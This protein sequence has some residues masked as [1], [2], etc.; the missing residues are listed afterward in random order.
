MTI[1]YLC[2]K[3]GK[4]PVSHIL[5][6]I[7]LTACS[8]DPLRSR[9]LKAEN[10]EVRTKPTDNLC[11]LCTEVLGIRNPRGPSLTEEQNGITFPSLTALPQVLRD[12]RRRP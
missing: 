10:Y 8:T 3:T 9:N 6:D 4:N 12:R 11:M 7:G 2:A 5:V 1:T